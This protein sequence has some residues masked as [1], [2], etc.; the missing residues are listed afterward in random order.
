MIKS[1]SQ[2]FKRYAIHFL[3]WSIFMAYEI[4]VIGLY[5]KKFGHPIAYGSHYLLIVFF[6]Y[7][8]SN[9]FLPWA[10]TRKFDAI[11]RF[12]VV[13]TVWMVLYVLI[14]FKLDQLLLKY[15]IA[16]DKGVM[17]I[18]WN[19]AYQV[20]YRAVYIL[21]FSSAYYFFSVYV[22]QRNLAENLERQRL[23]QIIEEEKMKRALSKSQNDFLKAQIN[24]HFLFNTL[25][26]V[27]QNVHFE[28]PEA[29][30]A[31]MAL[32]AM[33]RYA[34]DANESGEYIRLGD[35]MEQVDK[36]IYLYQLRKNME[37]PII[38]DFREEAMEIRFIPLVLMTLVENIFKHGNVADTQ[39][40]IFI[41]V[42]IEEE[43]LVM[44]TLNALNVQTH[45]HSTR[46]GLKNIRQRL[47]FAYGK[48]IDCSFT[49]ADGV[50]RAI[51]SIPLNR[52]THQ[53]QRRQLLQTQPN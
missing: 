49:E 42:R 19:Y 33:M 40:G 31:I 30:E 4:I 6:F 15:G 46:S 18:S 53:E 41:S 17:E 5:A 1:I 14:N 47:Q 44:E 51:V 24:P 35:E 20:I 34:V 36:L 28:S 22:K 8:F 9:Y 12:P 11:W 27:Y 38:T 23:H 37:L 7:G 26:Y 21:G 48:D 29:G 39:T 45:R 2:W 3:I 10:L 43:Q 50:F 13:L 25:D 32:S 52:I 16:P